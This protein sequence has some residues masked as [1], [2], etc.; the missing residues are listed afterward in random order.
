MPV[1]K[2]GSLPLNYQVRPKDF[3][4]YSIGSVLSDKI[5]RDALKDKLVVVGLTNRLMHDIHNTPFGSI[6]GVLIVANFLL[7]ILSG[8]YITEA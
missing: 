4:R 2:D 5:P 1:K 8:A 7:M 6:P 3:P